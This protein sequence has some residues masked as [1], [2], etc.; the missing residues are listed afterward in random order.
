MS[1][2]NKVFE[3]K[4]IANC[5]DTGILVCCNNA[6]LLCKPVLNDLQVTKLKFSFLPK[7]LFSIR[8]LFLTYLTYIEY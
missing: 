4:K 2:L 7:V 6:T 1:Y 8:E 3:K 5:K